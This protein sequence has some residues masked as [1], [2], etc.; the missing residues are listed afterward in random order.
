MIKTFV[1]ALALLIAWA[2]IGTIGSDVLVTVLRF[3][4]G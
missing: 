3:V 4:A 1:T 2:I